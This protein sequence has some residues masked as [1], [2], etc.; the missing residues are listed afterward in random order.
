LKHVAELKT[1]D[2]FG[3]LALIYGA[4]RSATVITSEPTELIVLSKTIY[5]KV[6]RGQHTH[7]IDQTVSFFQ[8]YA[9]LR[10][11]QKQPIIDLA[12]KCTLMKFYTNTV[13]AR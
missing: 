10:S 3:E 2:S 6:I 11:V 9:P 12:N 5:D 13:V 7:H 8:T 1:G 4:A